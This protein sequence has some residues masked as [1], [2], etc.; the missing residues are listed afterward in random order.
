MDQKN[1]NPEFSI[2][3]N[4]EI[5]HGEYSNLALITH[6]ASDFVLDFAALLPGLPKPKVRSRIIMAPE[7]AK[8]L[9]QAL[10]D[11]IY[12]YEQTFGKIEMHNQPPRTIAP[13]NGGKGEA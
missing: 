3:L 12:K 8:R 11:N 13:F 7:H 6:S 5:A 2:E 1:N 4:P 10:Q 9:L